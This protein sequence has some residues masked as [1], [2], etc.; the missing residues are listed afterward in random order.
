MKIQEQPKSTV[1]LDSLIVNYFLDDAFVAEYLTQALENEDPRQ[2]IIAFQ[3]VIK[4]REI[5]ISQLAIK[6]KM[7]RTALYKIFAYRSNPGYGTLLK[8]MHA[9][10][11]EF[12]AVKQT[13]KA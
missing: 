1:S 2:F 3:R 7:S 8:L 11:F 13:K 5:P 6:A 12:Q 9:I 4:G 10:G